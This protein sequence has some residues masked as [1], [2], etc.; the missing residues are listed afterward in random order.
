MITDYFGPKNENQ[1]CLPSNNKSNSQF[2]SNELIIQ[3]LSNSEGNSTVI[4]NN[5][6]IN[7]NK[8]L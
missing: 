4:N 7:E 3:N 2:K 5:Y 6:K 1:H 8:V